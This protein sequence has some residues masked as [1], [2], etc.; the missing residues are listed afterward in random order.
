ML[1]DLRLA[2]VQVGFEGHVATERLERTPEPAD[3]TVDL[4][5]VE[6]RDVG[7]ID[8]SARDRKRGHAAGLQ[9]RARLRG[10]KRR[11]DAKRQRAAGAAEQVA[12]EG[13]LLHQL[14]RP[15]LIVRALEEE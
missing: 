14:V 3:R 6:A 8:R 7:K 13:R 9:G 2:V 5:L 1:V 12:V 4:R 11:V 15:G 10:E